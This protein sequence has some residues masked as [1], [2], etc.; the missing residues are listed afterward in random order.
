VVVQSPSPKK[1]DVI[2][3]EVRDQMKPFLSPLRASP[4]RGITE[5]DVCLQGLSGK[6]D[7]QAENDDVSMKGTC[8]KVTINQKSPVQSPKR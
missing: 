7:L 6:S 8:G 1:V 3:A 2:L 4:I 5:T